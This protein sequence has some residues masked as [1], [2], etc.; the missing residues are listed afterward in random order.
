MATVVTADPA[1]WGRGVRE[2]STSVSLIP[3]MQWEHTAVSR[4]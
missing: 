2:T 1:M 3:V 4:W